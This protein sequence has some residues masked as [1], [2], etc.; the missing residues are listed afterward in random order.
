MKS[1]RKPRIAGMTI[2]EILVVVAILF[3]L[4]GVL[5]PVFVQ[6]RRAGEKA[7]CQSNLRQIGLALA[8]YQQDWDGYLPDPEAWMGARIGAPATLH[9][10]SISPDALAAGAGRGYPGYALSTRLMGRPL[11]IPVA[12]ESGKVVR[13]G[14]ETGVPA[15]VVRYP[16]ATI[17]VGETVPGLYQMG[18]V[19][20]TAFDH[21]GR[22]LAGTKEASERHNGGVNYLFLDGHVDW[23]PPKALA[24]VGGPEN[25][26]T[27]PT[28]KL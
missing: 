3:A 19:P 15:A 4:S 26:G 17:V 2:A 14:V 25:D 8:A 9:C 28:F 24:G 23:L 6:Q 11:P 7:S 16:S 1:R 5:F 22:E 27:R 12:D 10:P 18:T 21:E 13:F 20:V